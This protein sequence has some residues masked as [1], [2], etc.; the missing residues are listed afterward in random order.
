MKGVFSAKPLKFEVLLLVECSYSIKLPKTAG[1]CREDP[2]KDVDFQ[3]SARSKTAAR[4]HE[5]AGLDLNSSFTKEEA[6]EF[7]L[8]QHVKNSRPGH[9]PRKFYLPA[10]SQESSICVVRTLKAYTYRTAQ[11]RKA[12]KLLVSFIAPHNAVS[13]Q[14]I[15]RW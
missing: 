2:L 8:P 3:T 5:L 10:F 13:S 6:W 9:P 4:A 15:S 11:I 12:R 1:A 14:T 7:T